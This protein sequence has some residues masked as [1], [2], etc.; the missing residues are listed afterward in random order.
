MSMMLPSKR[1]ILRCMLVA[2]LSLKVSYY[3]QFKFFL[4]SLK[5]QSYCGKLHSQNKSNNLLTLF[6]L[7]DKWGKM[8]IS[9]IREKS[10][11][12]LWFLYAYLLYTSQIDGAK[13]VN[14]FSMF[15][16]LFSK[17]RSISDINWFM[18]WFHLEFIEKTFEFKVA[19]FVRFI[20]KHQTGV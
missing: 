20:Y 13:F 19:Y 9:P 5:E 4:Y 12:K 17:L 18:N 3:I 14:D 11:I 10:K 7:L 6:M 1:Q 2:W 8:V 16:F 15:I